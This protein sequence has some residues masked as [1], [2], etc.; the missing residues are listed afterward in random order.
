MAS[1][2]RLRRQEKRK[3][4]DG[5]R[6]HTSL[7]NAKVAASQSHWVS[8]VRAYKCKHCPYY[9]VGHPSHEL[10]KQLRNES[11]R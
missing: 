3:A 8:L 4:C 11:E 6:R 10:L 1:K 5:K 2:R 7:Q 9:H